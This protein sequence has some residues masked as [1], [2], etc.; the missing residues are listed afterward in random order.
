M[1]GRGTQRAPEGVG[2]VTHPMARSIQLELGMPTHAPARQ[3]PRRPVIKPVS[4][5]AC[6]SCGGPI[7]RG[8]GATVCVVC[9]V[10]RARLN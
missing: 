8:E 7:V 10:S 4:L 6:A 5:P 1:S 3:L 2:T 9:G